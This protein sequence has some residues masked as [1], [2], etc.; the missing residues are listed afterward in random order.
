MHSTEFELGMNIIGHAYIYRRTKKNS[1]HYGV[2]VLK[3][4]NV[5]LAHWI[6]FKFGMYIIGH[7]PTHNI[8]F[9]VYRN[10][11]FITGY[12]E[13]FLYITTCRLKIFE[14]HFRIVKLH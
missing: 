4:A 10:Y 7:R 12:I 11:R 13:N 6:E 8:V 9:S 14:V 3:Y 1:M 2:K 5:K